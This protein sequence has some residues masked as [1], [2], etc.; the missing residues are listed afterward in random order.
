MI[1]EIG[2]CGLGSGVTGFGH[3]Q[4]IR[5]LEKWASRLMTGIETQNRSHKE[6]WFRN[7]EEEFGQILGAPGNKLVNI[8][9]LWP[10]R[11]YKEGTVT[12]YSNF[13]SRVKQRLRRLSVSYLSPPLAVWRRALKPSPLKLKTGF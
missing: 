5:L 8:E 10:G 12:W 1:C 4:N 9:I 13:H 6:T 3:Q 2:S 11:T 7:L